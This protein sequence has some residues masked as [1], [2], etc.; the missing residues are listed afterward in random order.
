[1]SASPNSQR[2]AS[3]GGAARAIY[4]SPHQEMAG[5]ASERREPDATRPSLAIL[6]RQAP[7]E[8]LESLEYWQ[9]QA[10]PLESLESLETPAT[11]CKAAQRQRLALPRARDSHV[12][13]VAHE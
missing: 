8:S 11:G 9:W 7:L 2:T 4:P 3:E 1:M 12:G 10:P 5:Q 6:G 13:P